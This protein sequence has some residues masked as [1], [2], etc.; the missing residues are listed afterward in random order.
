VEGRDQA[1]ND[2]TTARYHIATPDYFRALGIPLVRGRF[3]DAHDDAKSAVVLIV[4][5]SMAKRYWPG[6][7]AIGKR[8]TFRG[9]P[10]EKDWM[11]IVG[12]VGDIRDEPGN[13]SVRPALWLAHAQESDRALSV[14]IRST[15]DGALVA[16]QLRAAVG[17]LDSE[18]AVSEVRLMKQVVKE[19][20]SSQRFALFLIGLFA[21]LALALA[22]IGMYGVISYSV[23]QRMQ[24]F[25]MRMA[26]GATGADLMRMIVGQS[27]KL[28]VVGAAIGLLGAA[29]LGRVLGNLLYGVSGA[30]PV[31]FAGVATL[32]LGTAIIAG[33]IPARRA[34]HADP[35][36]S[37]RAE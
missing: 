12:I 35:M 7:D 25:G 16:K 10:E 17:Q 36:D 21:V 2:K 32:A 23:N 33:Y 5:E 22:T 34:T 9:R 4:N 13:D 31:T 29:V 30:D 19:S 8:I 27:V 11:R 37:L 14:A 3:F 6:E 1:Y 26:L 20:V 24:E 28:A 18:L 15:S